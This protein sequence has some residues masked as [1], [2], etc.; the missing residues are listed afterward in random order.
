MRD[1]EK[2]RES[3]QPRKKST[4]MSH[5]ERDFRRGVLQLMILLLVRLNTEEAHGY[6]LIKIIRDTGVPLKAGT[7]YPLLKRLENDGLIQSILAD[8]LEHPGQPRRIYTMTQ[9]GEEVIY[10]MMEI[11]RDYNNSIKIW[12]D[13]IKKSE[14]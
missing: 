9:L 12:F 7:I 3:N 8:D 4:L 11:Y 14:R 2:G 10:D 1:T 13:E 5:W 6:G